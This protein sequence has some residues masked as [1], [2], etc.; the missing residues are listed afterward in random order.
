LRNRQRALH[1]A[2]FHRQHLADLQG[3]SRLAVDATLGITGLV[4]TMHRTIQLRPGPIGSVHGAERTRGITGFVYRCVRGT[5]RLVGTGLDAA[6][7]PIAALLPA[8]ESSAER[9]AAVAALN[10]VYGDYLARTGNP[11]AIDMS[12]RYRDRPLD[13]DAPGALHDELG[14]RGGNARLLLMVH[15]L[16]LNERHWRREGHDHG[17]ALAEALGYVPVYL[18]YNTGLP[19][20]GNGR[21]L[22]GLLEQL[23]ANWPGAAPELAIVGHSMGGLVIRSACHHARTARHAWIGRLR[24]CVFLGTPHHG[25]PLERAGHWLNQA[26]DLSPYAAP[27]TR[28]GRTRSAGI[29]DLR[30]GSVTRRQRECVPL[31]GRVRFYAAAATLGTRRGVLAD[32]LL[33]DGLVPLESALGR[34]RDPSRELAIP[35]RRQWIG[36]DLGHLDLL[37]DPRVYAQ[38]RRWLSPPDSQPRHT[39]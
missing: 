14:Q 29:A 11:L 30:H 5:T 20:A 25:A 27:F 1:I 17:A 4:E 38:L 18:R 6:L 13:A 31:P 23:L 12:L 36:Y 16:C 28:L 15:G 7:S 34:H 22:A 3:A 9:D 33:G 26:M 2:T 39:P 8:G 37:S 35:R 24:D 10:G 19:V 21:A 32:R